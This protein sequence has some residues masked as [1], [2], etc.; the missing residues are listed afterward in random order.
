MPQ[1][2]TFE[3]THPHNK[4]TYTETLNLTHEEHEKLTQYLTH[5]LKE[6]PMARYVFKTKYGTELDINPLRKNKYI[7]IICTTE[8]NQHEFRLTEQQ[9]KQID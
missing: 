1:P 5:I 9:A 8:T 7:G 6:N 3:A 4:Q 2:I